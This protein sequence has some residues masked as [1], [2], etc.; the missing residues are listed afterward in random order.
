VAVIQDNKVLFQK[1]YAVKSRKSKELV[2]DNTIFSIGSVSKAFTAVGVMQLVQKGKIALDEPVKKYM[3]EIP[4]S[5]GN[6]TIKQLRH[7]SAASRM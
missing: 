7:I 6:I 5:W 2:N 1:T 4:E 3:K